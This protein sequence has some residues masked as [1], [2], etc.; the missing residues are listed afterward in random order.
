[1]RIVDSG[2]F[3]V[4]TTVA[5]AMVTCSSG[6]DFE[7]CI[8]TPMPDEWQ[9]YVSGRGR[10]TVVATGNRARTVDFQAGDVG[11]VEKTLLHYMNLPLIVDANRRR[12]HGDHLDRRGPAKPHRV[13]GTLRRVRAAPRRRAHARAPG[14][15]DRR[16]ERGRGRGCARAR[17]LAIGVRVPRHV[18]PSGAPGRRRS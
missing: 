12:D 16:R 5:M 3:K 17:S 6:R 10:M 7:N 15:E 11:Y 14:E 18:G 9:Y 13:P 4:S 8:G 2:A 1:V